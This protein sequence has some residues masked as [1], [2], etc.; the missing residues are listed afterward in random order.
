MA[1]NFRSTDVFY[2]SEIVTTAVDVFLPFPLCLNSRRSG[3]CSDKI[4]LVTIRLRRASEE[5]KKELQKASAFQHLTLFLLCRGFTGNFHM[6]NLV[7][8]MNVGTSL[9]KAIK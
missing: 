3:K 1:E 9:E 6:V 2:L 5:R 4:V 7:T 8:C